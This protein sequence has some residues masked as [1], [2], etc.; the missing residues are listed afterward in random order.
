MTISYTTIITSL[1]IKFLKNLLFTKFFFN[2]VVFF[3]M[4]K[5]I[6]NE[7]SEDFLEILKNE[8][9]LSSTIEQKK[10]FVTTDAWL[11]QLGSRKNN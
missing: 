8:D 5:N 2:F 11:A 7:K 3:I 9:N 10:L 6:D 1:L 4:A